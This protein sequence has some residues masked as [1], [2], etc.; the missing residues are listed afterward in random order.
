M[1]KFWKKIRQNLIWVLILISLLMSSFDTAFALS[2]DQEL[3][4]VD[5]YIGDE[6]SVGRCIAKGN[7][8]FILFLKSA[9]YS[10]GLFEG[11]YEPFVD[12]TVRNQ[13]QT[14]DI[15][16]LI[17]QRDKIREYIRG[18]FLKCQND[19]IPNLR[20]A[21]TQVN[22][23]IYYVRHVVDSSVISNL[24]TFILNDI[25]DVNPEAFYYDKLSLYKD[26][27]ERYVNSGQINKD[28]FEVFFSDLDSRYR[29]RKKSYVICEDN[30][31][32]ELGEKWDEFAN[33]LGGLSSSAEYA[34]KKLGGSA[35]KIMENFEDGWLESYLTGVINLNINGLDPAMA[36]D[37]ILAD[38][39][40][41][42][43]IPGSDSPTPK[44]YK[45]LLDGLGDEDFRYNMEISKE[46]LRSKYEVLYKD[47][48]DSSI[49]L[50]VDELKNLDDVILDSLDDIDNVIKCANTMNDRQCP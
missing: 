28:D 27:K 41:A 3:G 18:A 42:L 25:L 37:E 10:D 43:Y 33:D 44:T 24:P 34:N 48:S 21:Y 30:A 16:A 45:S 7:I 13:C 8:D 35:E 50:F 20:R 26:M 12:I 49:E 38:L 11:V 31:W 9:I 39:D 22:A 46:I 14:I 40:Q 6:L 4:L 17:K 29:N 15:S 36:F 32:K 47:S 2:E 19:R 1:N 5:P 23:E